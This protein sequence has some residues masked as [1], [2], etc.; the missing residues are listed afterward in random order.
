M[1]T[2]RETPDA[3]TVTFLLSS[4]WLSDRGANPERWFASLSNGSYN[5]PSDN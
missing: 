3:L 4:Y 2:L 1:F 5:M